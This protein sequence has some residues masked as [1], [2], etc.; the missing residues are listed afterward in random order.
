MIRRLS[1]EFEMDIVEERGTCA[2]GLDAQ[3]KCPG[4]GLEFPAGES[5]VGIGCGVDHFGAI[6]EEGVCSEAHAQGVGSALAPGGLEAEAVAVSGFETL[7]GGFH[8]GVILKDG[9]LRTFRRVWRAKR[10]EIGDDS[11]PAREE[12]WGPSDLAVVLVERSGGQD[13]IFKSTLGNARDGAGN[14]YRVDEKGGVAAGGL[15][16]DLDVGGGAE[17]VERAADDAAEGVGP[18]DR[19]RLAVEGG[20]E[21]ERYGGARGGAGQPA[22]ADKIGDGVSFRRIE[23]AD[24]LG[25]DPLALDEGGVGAAVGGLLV[26]ERL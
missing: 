12:T 20:S 15:A 19:F 3:G 25:D 1:A 5:L 2:D 24:G 17:D 22:F 10:T 16:A 23:A 11:R 4:G 13:R 6:K 14:G 7:E 18:A 9:G 8:G 21:I 26:E